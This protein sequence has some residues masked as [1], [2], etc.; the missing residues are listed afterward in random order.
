MENTVVVVAAGA[1]GQKILFRVN[2]M[3]TI[4]QRLRD[5]ARKF[6]RP[7]RTPWELG[8]KTVRS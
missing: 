1:E 5:F 7:P 2:T 8:R 4:K 3:L 6:R